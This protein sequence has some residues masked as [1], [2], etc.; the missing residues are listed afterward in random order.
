LSADRRG[1]LRIRLSK[2]ARAAV[3]NRASKAD[4]A[5]ARLRFAATRADAE[6]RIVRRTLRVVP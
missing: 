5:L 1:T 3:L 6:P 2:R 4:P